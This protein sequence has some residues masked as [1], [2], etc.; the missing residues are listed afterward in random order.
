MILDTNAVSDFLEGNP[1][2][3]EVF[4]DSRQVFIPTVVLGEFLFGI[5]RS[6]NK[7]VIEAHLDA[8]LEDVEVLPIT[9]NTARSYASV[10]LDLASKGRPIPEVDMWIAALGREFR[11]PIVSRDTH[12][13][14][15]PG[16][17]RI[18]W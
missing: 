15:V 6:R 10:R 11:M 5:G 4:E 7:A 3:A 13:D 12:F 8:L 9:L 18:G 2:V 17:K 16:I 14:Q 1:L